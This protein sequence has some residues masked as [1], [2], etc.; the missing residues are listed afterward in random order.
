MDDHHGRPLP[1]WFGD[2]K[3]GIMIH[4]SLFSVPGYAPVP[5]ADF[6]QMQKRYG[7]GYTLRHTP[8][9]EWY[10]N[11]L[12]IAGSST[13]EFHREH[14]GQGF[15]YEDFRIA[16]EAGSDELDPARWAGFFEQIHA[17]YVVL[18]TKHHDGYQLWPS[19]VPNPA[20]PGYFS[21]RDL[22]GELTAAVRAR[23]LRM[24]LY[25]SGLLDWT[26]TS[27]P[28]AS[29]YDMLLQYHVPAVQREY[30]IGQWK[31]LIDRYAPDILWNDIGYPDQSR[32]DDLF[33]YYY[34][35]V[36]DGVVNDRWFQHSFPG[37]ILRSGL[38]KRLVA[39]I[40]RTA[41]SEDAGSVHKAK[42]HHDYTTPEYFAHAEVPAKKWESVRGIGKSFGYNRMETE[43]DHLTGP[44]LIWLLADVVSKNGNLLVNVGPLP[45]GRIPACQKAPLAALGEWLGVNGE[46]IFATR[47]WTKPS[48]E[49]ASGAQV[50][51]T[52]TS[53]AV[54][55][56][57][58]GHT[59]S[60]A[61]SLAL[62][63][64][65]PKGELRLLGPGATL[66]WRL[67]AGTLQVE[68]P[69]GFTTAQPFVLKW[70][71]A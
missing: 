35:A 55:V 51:F 48:A 27:Q 65:L 20:A 30:L 62:P 41:N 23:G 37:F 1:A 33:R 13:Q 53:E 32:V 22:V 68:L 10:Q 38:M 69:E 43:G 25:Y 28:L 9:A 70:L 5:E 71:Q 47:P 17:K 57:V 45:D 63:G 59:G 60:S 16:F 29:M 64:P 36:P 15:P 66:P 44:E 52:Q 2:A 3:F 50:R 56:I 46:A 61:L 11:S 6:A 24:G 7:M 42:F 40:E 58:Q 4:W 12:R 18:V 14:F 19:S 26:F 31:E 67:D 8:Y 21:R 49:T 39:H 34:G 54:Y